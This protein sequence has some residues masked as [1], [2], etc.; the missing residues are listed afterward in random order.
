MRRL[1]GCVAVGLLL[2]LI[3][4]ESALA[5]S[6]PPRSG[7][8]TLRTYDAALN[9]RLIEVV[10]DPP[11]ESGP[12]NRSATWRFRITRVFKGERRYNLEKGDVVEMRWSHLNSCEYPL[13]ERRRYGLRL[14]KTR[15]HGFQ[16]NVCPGFSP[17]TLRKAAKRSGRAR[18]SPSGGCSATAT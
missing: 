1:V 6:C 3:G 15:R 16:I 13:R 8:E 9:A 14:W 2:S 4:A 7:P 11:P 10:D 18:S 17:K 5:C 12:W